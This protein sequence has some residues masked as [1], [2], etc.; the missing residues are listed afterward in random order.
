MAVTPLDIQTRFAE[1]STTTDPIIQMAIDEASIEIQKRDW[2]CRYD[3]GLAYL[4]AHLLKTTYYAS[5]NPSAN[6]S[7]DS[8]GGVKHRQVFETQMSWYENSVYS[9]REESST[10]YGLRYLELRNKLFVS[11]TFC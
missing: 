7:S 9:D 10:I 8:I 3:I 5:A 6:F 2:G 4:T 11:R 1:F